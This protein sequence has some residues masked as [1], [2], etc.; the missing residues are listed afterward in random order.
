MD[1]NSFMTLGLELSTPWKVT[2]SE[3]DIQSNPSELRLRIDAPRGSLFPCPVCGKPCKAHD[4]SD[5]SWRHLNFFQH[6]C[7]I[8]ASVPRVNCPEHG[9]HRVNVPWARPRSGFTLLFEQ[10]IMSLAAHMPIKTIAD[11]VGETDKRLWRVIFYYV[12][13][14]M[15]SID[16]TDL[17]GIGLDE[18]AIKRGHKYIT[19]FIDMRKDDHPVI[20]ATPGKGKSTLHEFATYLEEHGGNSDNI[21]EIVS[22]MSPAF[23]SGSSEYFRYASLTV[24]WFHVVQLFVNAVDKVRK[25]EGRKLKMPKACR[26]AVLKNEE[27]WKTQEQEEALIELEKGGY[28]TA[29]AFRVKELLR[30]IRGA[31]TKR[32][33]RWRISRFLNRAKELIAENKLLEPVRKALETVRIQKERILWRWESMFTNARLESL[34]GLFQAARTRAR[35]YRN[36]KTFITMVYLIGAPIQKMLD[37]MLG[38]QPSAI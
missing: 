37:A 8:T 33:A 14:A 13:K 20:F 32:Q 21:M 34:N 16:L 25:L 22:D 6:H 12:D 15:E 31:D 9:I 10:A 5:L 27:S 30:W 18:T 3:L 36:E 19:I 38:R 29:I 26:W 1:T 35:G 2:A 7:L 23:Q 11:Y 4:F 24:D 28:A 17:Y